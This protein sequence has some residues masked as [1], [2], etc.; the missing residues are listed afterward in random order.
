MDKSTLL[1]GGLVLNGSVFSYLTTDT[2]GFFRN[3]FL[4][5][6]RIFGVSLRF[7]PGG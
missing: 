4:T 7:A 3:Y 1:D 6:P 5:E 2:S